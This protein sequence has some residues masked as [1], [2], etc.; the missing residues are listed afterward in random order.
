MNGDSRVY[1]CVLKYNRHLGVHYFKPV[2]V[3]YVKYSINFPHFV[4]IAYK[5]RR[6][7]LGIPLGSYWLWSKDITECKYIKGGYTPIVNKAN[8]GNMG[9]YK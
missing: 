4:P 5:V 6:K 7:F 2:N 8:Y 1:L 3:V 9:D